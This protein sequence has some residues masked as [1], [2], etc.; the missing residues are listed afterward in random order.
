MNAGEGGVA[1]AAVHLERHYLGDTIFR[2]PER[3]QRL[4]Q[5]ETERAHNPGRDDGYAGAVCGLG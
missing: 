1:A 5:P 3:S 4:L 2:L